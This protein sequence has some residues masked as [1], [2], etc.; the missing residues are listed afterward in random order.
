M[1]KRLGVVMTWKIGACA[2]LVVAA[3][4][5]GVG[6]GDPRVGNYSG[7]F[8]G[9]G[10]VGDATLWVNEDG[11]AYLD[12][13]LNDTVETASEY[14]PLGGFSPDLSFKEVRNGLSN[15]VRYEVKA[16]LSQDGQRFTGTFTAVESVLGQ[17]D[18]PP[19]QCQL[20][21]E[22][23][24]WD[25]L[26]ADSRAGEFSCTGMASGML[27]PY[28]DFGGSMGVSP[29][30]PVPSCFGGTLRTVR[31]RPPVTGLYSIRAIM[32]PALEGDLD[33]PIAAFSSC[34]GKELAC[35]ATPDGQYAAGPLSLQLNGFQDVLIVSAGTNDISFEDQLQ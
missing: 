21:M 27:L 11:Y 34:T 4:G 35:S 29:A 3:V 32:T 8:T 20:A 24:A 18:R 19:R 14:H 2:V 28:G 25:P 7:A 5:C 17:P 23:V 30:A 16:T 6:P 12:T 31:A 10:P 26:A 15:S 9:C 22:R 13:D 1:L 33:R